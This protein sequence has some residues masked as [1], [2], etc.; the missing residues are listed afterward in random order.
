MKKT[1]LV[2]IILGVMLSACGN[3][4]SAIVTA[5]AETEAARPTETPIPQTATNTPEPSATYTLAP[6]TTPTI[7]KTQEYSTYFFEVS[8][9]WDEWIIQLAGTQ[10]MFNDIA[11]DESV[12]NDTTWKKDSLKTAY[13]LKLA[14]DALATIENVP[15]KH[16]P[17][18]T[19]FVE[20]AE[21]ATTFYDDIAFFL[22]A[23]TVFYRKSVV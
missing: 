20:L 17:L 21:E 3:S 5:I 4:E 19:L 14:A 1:I 7:D 22:N 15:T 2:L 16:I 13:S 11:E 18:Q 12:L 9:R 6:T 23:P 10:Q 8:S